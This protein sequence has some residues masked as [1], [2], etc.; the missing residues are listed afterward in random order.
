MK[1]LLLAVLAMAFVGC[2]SSTNN[3]VNTVVCDVQTSVA[4]ASA[5]AVA[6][7]LACANTSVI[8]ADIN[9]ELAKLNLC[10]PAT[11]SGKAPEKGPIGDAICASVVSSI[12]GLFTA[13]IPAT[14]ACTGGKTVAEV[15][16]LLLPICQKSISI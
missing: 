6:G 3:T 14:W 8:Q 4:A 9:T 2:T 5:S 7:A 11:V 1:K 15:N 13:K 16:A 12:T 10:K